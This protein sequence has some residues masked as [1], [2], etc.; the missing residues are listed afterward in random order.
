MS[1][2]FLQENM[3]VFILSAY[4]R[5]H[6]DSLEIVLICNL[7]KKLIISAGF[8]FFFKKSCMHRFVKKYFHR[9]RFQLS[10]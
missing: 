1:M 5:A 6:N 2:V 7:V 8:F 3:L 10:R 4:S 9:L